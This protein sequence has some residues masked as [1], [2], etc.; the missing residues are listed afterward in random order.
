MASVIYALCAVT[1]TAC[2]WLLLAGYRRTRARLLLW[3]G[4]CFIGLLINNVLVFV[5]IVLVPNVDLYTWRNL[6]AV[7]GM[8]ILL[9]GLIWDV[10]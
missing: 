8:G 1:S 6:A 7:V 9:Y 2:A 4:L 3:A 5:D 10:R